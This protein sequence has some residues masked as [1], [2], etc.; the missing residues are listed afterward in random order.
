MLRPCCTRAEDTR[1]V[2]LR[3]TLTATTLPL[4]QDPHLL[5]TMTP[6]NMCHM[7]PPSRLEHPPPPPPPPPPHLQGPPPPPPPH[8]H[9][10][11]YPALQRDMYMKAEPL[12]PPYGIGQGMAPADLHHAQQSQMLHQLLQQ[13]GAE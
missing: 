6:E 10:P 2:T 12:M 4:F 5:R 8:P 11:H 3:A 7:T 13:H 1:R 9:T